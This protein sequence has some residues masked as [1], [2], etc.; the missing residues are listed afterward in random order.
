M[1][2]ATAYDEVVYLDQN[3]R[4]RRRPGLRVLH[5]AR[6]AGHYVKMVHNG[7]CHHARNSEVY[8]IMRKV[9][10]KSNS[11]MATFSEWDKGDLNAYLIEI[12]SKVL[13]QKDDPTD[14]DD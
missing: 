6:R 14:D 13:R 3:G 5:R 7:I 4:Y 8:D 9:A 2:V 11:E 1:P 12:A 10:H